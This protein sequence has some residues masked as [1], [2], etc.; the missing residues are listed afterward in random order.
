VRAAGLF[1]PSKVD[2]ASPVPA[3]Q[4]LSHHA[5]LPTK[6]Q[7]HLAS[8][9]EIYLGARKFWFTDRFADRF[10]D[11]SHHQWCELK[12]SEKTTADWP[13]GTLELECCRSRAKLILS[14][15]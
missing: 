10:P 9:I 7:N 11:A 8:G 2:M 13:D 1:P 12:G 15:L 4:P 14:Y 6:A 3:K 5:W